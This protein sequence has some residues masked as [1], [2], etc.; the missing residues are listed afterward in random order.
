M[1][2]VVIL[3]RVPKTSKR[4]EIVLSE[5]GLG[6]RQSRLS[7]AKEIIGTFTNKINQSLKLTIFYMYNEKPTDCRF[8]LS[9]I[10]LIH[11]TLKPVGQD[12]C[13]ET[14]AGNPAEMLQVPTE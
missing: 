1:D 6:N 8:L 10:I 5:N 9:Y 11:E 4:T 3:A 7:E 14:K 12:S 2:K 13:E